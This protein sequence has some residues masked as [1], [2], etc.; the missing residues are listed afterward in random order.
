MELISANPRTAVA[1]GDDMTALENMAYAQF[2]AD[3][4]FN[5]ASLGYVHTMAHQL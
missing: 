4:A 1:Q 2:V 3:M 5:T